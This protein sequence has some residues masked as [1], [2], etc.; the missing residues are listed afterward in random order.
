M[1]I[2]IIVEV[3][4]EWL[5]MNTYSVQKGTV[6]W[7]LLRASSQFAGMIVKSVIKVEND[8]DGVEFK[9]RM[10]KDAEMEELCEKKRGIWIL[11]TP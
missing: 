5:L 3:S 8:R 4:I 2:E 7:I 9:A 10:E 6:F 11:K 1:K